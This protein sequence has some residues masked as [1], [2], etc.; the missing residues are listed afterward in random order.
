ML[1][2]EQRGRLRG[3]AKAKTG[4]PE[5][6]PSPLVAYQQANIPD[7][8]SVSRV[9]RRPGGFPL[10]WIIVGGLV[11][12]IGGAAVLQ[13]SKTA[14]PKMPGPTTVAAKPPVAE[15]SVETAVQTLA[16]GGGLATFSEVVGTVRTATGCG[17]KITPASDGLGPLYGCI[18]GDAETAKLFV[19]GMAGG[20]GT[21]NIKVMWNQWTQDTGYGVGPDRA[22]AAKFARRVAQRYAPTLRDNVVAAFMSD[23]EGEVVFKAEGL[24][25]TVQKSTGPMIREHLLTIEAGGG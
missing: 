2:E 16:V 3:L 22:E 1:T 17:G 8:L 15:P 24:T 10:I 7:P 25:L 9:H 20:A 11:V 4:E 18:A 14:P 5:L 13:S 23:V 19:N 21:R 12:L 6:E